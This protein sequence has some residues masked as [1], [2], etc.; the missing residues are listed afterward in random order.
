MLQPFKTDIYVYAN[1]PEEALQVSNLWK[2][3]VMAKRNQGVVV[4]AEKLT[5]AIKTFGDNPLIT[6]FLKSFD[7]AY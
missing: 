4:S 7:Y 3:F 5:K 1:S 6:N 2:D